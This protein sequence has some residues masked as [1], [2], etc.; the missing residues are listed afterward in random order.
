MPPR[1]EVSG[2]AGGADGKGG[3]ARLK[4]YL[5][6]LRLSHN[7]DAPRSDHPA[8]QWDRLLGCDSPDAGSCPLS[9]LPGTKW[10]RL[11]RRATEP[12]VDEP[13]LVLANHREGRMVGVRAGRLGGSTALDSAAMPR[14]GVQRPRHRH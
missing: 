7:E 8:H 4:S 11:V 3:A 14:H 13:G 1:R 9:V 10:Q 5:S 2:D 6:T 12:D